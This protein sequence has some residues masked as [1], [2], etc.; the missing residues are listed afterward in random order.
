MVFAEVRTGKPARSQAFR[1]T[2]IPCSASGMAQPMITSST[3]FGSSPL[4]R[5]IAS[6]ITMA[7]KSSGR[8]ARNV[9]LVGFPIAVRTELTITA[10][11]IV[12]LCQNGDSCWLRD[13]WMPGGAKKQQ[14]GDP[15]AMHARFM[16]RGIGAYLEGVLAAERNLSVTMSSALTATPSNMEGSY[17]QRLSA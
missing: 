2:F 11:R 5:A 9:P 13:Y 1:A 3:S 7:A 15:L 17:F 16:P 6:V 14:R 10:S 12:H 8:V 4:A